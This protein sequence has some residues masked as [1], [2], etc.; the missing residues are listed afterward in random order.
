M[1]TMRDLEE[2][3]L[4]RK[5]DD[6]EKQKLDKV[7]KNITKMH[8]VYL[9]I[10]T[11]VCGGSKII[12][13]YAN[14][15]SKRGHKITIISYYRKPNWFNLSEN[16][17]FIQV[18]ENEL[19]EDN[20]PNCDLIIS[21]SWKNIYSAIVSK[22]A[23]VVFFEQGGAHLFEIGNLSDIKF[24]AVKKRIDIVPFIQT[25]STYSQNT[26]KKVYFRDS[27]VIYNAIDKKIFYPRTDSN[28]SK[29]IEITIIGSEEFR[30]KNIEESL[31]AIRLLKDKYKDRIN[32][33]WITQEQPKKNKEEAIVNPKQIEIGNILRKTDIFLCNS[34]YESFGLPV[35]EAMSCGAC[36]ITTDTGGTKDIVIDK[37]NAIYIKKHSIKDIVEK[38]ELLIE[39][40][41]LMH[42][43][44]MNGL[45]TAQK[46]SWKKSI[47]DA[48]QYYREI[49]Q[50]KVLK[51]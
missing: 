36:V 30:F 29:K 43:I 37:E 40:S 42:K 39:N 35:L 4:S 2:M 46:F 16:V 49:C 38:A 33:N 15:L 21:T 31:Q 14:R 32:L 3:E 7:K 28:T 51:N 34:E 9:M 18:K 1:Y 5:I 24:K 48:E 22:K 44:S 23:P 11:K 13:E 19:I 47:D 12:L 45:K 26:I 25:V 41:E 8:I 50:Y 27:K 17:Q 20:I 6:L 10:W